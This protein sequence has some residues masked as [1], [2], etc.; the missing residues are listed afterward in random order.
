M[1]WIAK[2]NPELG[3]A[4]RYLEEGL[5]NA[6]PFNVNQEYIGIALQLPRRNG[7]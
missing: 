7:F 4:D 2:S 6:G 1:T 3:V 5:I